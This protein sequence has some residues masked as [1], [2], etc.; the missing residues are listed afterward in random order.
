VTESGATIIEVDENAHR[1]YEP[2]CE[3]ARYDTLMYGS[4]QL[5][6]T[7][8]IRFNPHNTRDNK[9]PLEDRA[10]ALVQVVR[11][12]LK[13][14]RT[15]DLP[16]M[17]IQYMFYN[18]VSLQP[19][20]NKSLQDNIHKQFAEMASATLKVLPVVTSTSS[21]V[22]DKDIAA[23]KL[24]DLTKSEMDAATNEV[25]MERARK[26]GSS[27]LQ[28]HAMNSVNNPIKKARCSGTTMKGQN[29][30]RWHFDVLAAGK[31][32]VYFDEGEDQKALK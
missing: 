16:I 31:Q 2:A 17:S 29:L 28:C 20:P 15:T 23:F 24:S 6:P 14:P 11:N 21:V 30:C 1:Y 5:R 27:R 25:M 26:L 13:T 4:D 8:A 22:L 10:K 12:S 9:E 18:S 3:L 32:I 19:L 7:T